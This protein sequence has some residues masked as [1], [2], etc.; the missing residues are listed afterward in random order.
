MNQVER[1]PT[2]E[3]TKR[4]LQWHA[5]IFLF[6]GMVSALVIM[7]AP[8]GVVAR[9][10]H[11]VAMLQAA[12]LFG[13]ASAWTSLNAGPRVLATIKYLALLGL[14]CNYTGTQIASLTKAKNVFFV[15]APLI[16]DGV[17]PS[18]EVLV[19]VMLSTSIVLIPAF[20]LFLWGM[21]PWAVK[22]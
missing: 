14:Y 2:L 20:G 6:I 15:T 22:K 19:T 5:S 10:A 7:V 9:A 3:Q 4:Q 8:V 13:V 11:V 12:V 17:H 1:S 16:P 21:R 18:M